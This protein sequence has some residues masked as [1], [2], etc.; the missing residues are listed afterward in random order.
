MQQN[1]LKKDDFYTYINQEW[2]KSN[3]IPSD[4]TRWSNFHVLHETNQSRLKEL[5]ESAVE[6]VEQKKL[7][8]I[9]NKGLD[10]LTLNKNGII[11][12]ND[13][14]SRFTSNIQA[15]S[16]TN[17]KDINEM[18]VH[19]LKYGLSFLFDFGS[20]SDLH[21]STRN[22][23][24]FDVGGLS[25]PDRDYYLSEKMKDKQDYYKDFLNTFLTHCNI[26]IE[27]NNIYSFEESN[28]KILLSKAERRDPVKLYNLYSFDKLLEDFPGI[29]WNHI[30]KEFN[31]ISNDKI[32]IS[33]PIY[34]A[35]ISD[36]LIKCANNN[37]LTTNLKQYY[38]YKFAKVASSFTDDLTYQIHFNFY[39]KQLMGQQQPKIR[40]KRVLGTI[41]SI[42]GEVLSKA[43]I[44]KYFSEEQKSSCINMIKEICITYEESIKNLDWM[45]AETKI[46]A[47]EK[48][49]T[50]TSKIGFPDKW[51]NFDKLYIGNELSYFENI[52]SCYKWATEH[53]LEELY[54]PVDRTKWYMN[55]HTINAYYQPDMN[56]ITFPAGILQEPFYSINQSLAE[57]LGGIGAV[58]G[59]E[60]THGFDDKGRLYDLNGNL[61]DWWTNEDAVNF[62]DRSKKLKEYFSSHKY[63]D[64][65]VNG[66]LTLGENIADL[67][68]LTLSIRT[69]KRLV[70][71]GENNQT[72]YKCE[73][74]KLFEQWAIIWRNNITDDALKNQLLTDPHSPGQLRANYILSNID[75]FYEI[76]DVKPE[77]KMYLSPE[78]RTK[79]W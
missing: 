57:N 79:I 62:D 55:A 11:D 20:S 70:G 8:I 26:N 6:T 3:P 19:F 12:I 59:H 75:E 65:N 38:K 13:I 47:L 33:E 58:I 36:Y 54:K 63:F 76:Y 27:S 50:F 40:W 39:G 31:I 32:V 43:Y 49:G 41:D 24:Y 4:Y 35:H 17:I 18:I 77:D 42:L 2:L 34:F 78:L 69:L 66:E 10:D 46:K 16:Q 64:I 29:P 37:E 56:N 73:L 71:T 28:A 74:A 72:Q 61:N 14:Y 60:M 25:L 30:F 67:G 51:T 23:L 1:V 7:N 44:Q 52:L 5:L 15:N 22:I 68:G 48:I 53:N 21:D 9:W 45:S